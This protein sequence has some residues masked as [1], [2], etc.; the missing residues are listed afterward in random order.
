MKKFVNALEGLFFGLKK[1]RSIKIQFFLGLLAIL[2]CFY[3]QIQ[4][5]EWMIVI[6]CI[7]LVLVSEY[8]NTAIEKMCD[9]YTND[10]HPTIKEIKDISAAAVFISALISFIIMLLIIIKNGGILL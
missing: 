8:F 7:G 6:L 2:Y 10:Y 1:D 3:L 9:A 5:M 4:L